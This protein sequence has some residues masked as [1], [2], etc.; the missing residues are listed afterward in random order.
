MSAEGLHVNKFGNIQ[1]VAVV[2]AAGGIADRDN[3]SS[4]VME[5][6]RRD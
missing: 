2:N 1:A 6:L 3:L 5:Q 4:R